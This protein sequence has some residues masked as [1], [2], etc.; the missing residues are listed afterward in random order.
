MAA[1]RLL[2]VLLCT[3]SS[4]WAGAMPILPHAPS[5]LRNG[6]F[7]RG[8]FSGWSF[9]G[10]RDYSQV[11]DQDYDGLAPRGGAD[12]ALLGARGSD[13]VLSQS[14]TD[15]PGS[16]LIIRFW[17]ASDG[18]SND[19][20]TASYDG[21]T[22]CALL[23]TGAFAWRRD[24]AIVRATGHD[25]LSFAFRDDQDYLA[26]DRVSVKELARPHA[27]A[28]AIPEPATALLL[29]PPLLLLARR[30]RA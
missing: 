1:F 4:A 29:A 24:V 13:G 3:A 28:D 14:F 16:L 12:Y 18:G 6:G 2:L 21:K 25:T 27:S 9:T 8:D 15:T 17:V 11:F 5:L 30:R 26:L 23:D 10:D 7:E 22:L 19:D 20:F